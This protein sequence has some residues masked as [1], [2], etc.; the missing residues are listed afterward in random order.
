MKCYF[1]K[2]LAYEKS[3]LRECGINSQR[4]LMV[5]EF[6]QGNGRNLYMCEHIHKSM[7]Y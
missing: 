7:K 5:Q 3:Y 1:F 6:L 4:E 2:E